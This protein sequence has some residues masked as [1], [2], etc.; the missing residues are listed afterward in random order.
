MIKKIRNQF[1]YRSLLHPNIKGNKFPERNFFNFQVMSKVHLYKTI[2]NRKKIS[3]NLG[4]LYTPPHNIAVKTWRNLVK[5][6][7]NNLG[8]WSISKK[9]S[10]DIGD[11]EGEVIHKMIDL[12]GGKK[13]T[14]G[15]ICD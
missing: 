4:S 7:P 6:N 12:L 13:N 2:L 9:P 14:T 8:N 11:L 15:G 10:W 5:L 3:N 1:L